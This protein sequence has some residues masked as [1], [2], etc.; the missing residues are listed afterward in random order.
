MS[1][2]PVRPPPS[3][4]ATSLSLL[5]KTKGGDPLAW[6]RFVYL[7]TPLVVRWC[8]RAGV[9]GADA[10]DIA[11]EVFVTVLDRLGGFAH[12]A[13]PGS[14]RGWLKVITRHK[15]G[16][17]IRR[18]RSRPQTAEIVLEHLSRGEDAVE[19]I[20]AERKLLAARALELLRTDFTEQTW[21]AFWRVVVD[22]RPVAEVARELG[23]SGN[24]VY[25]AKY[26]VLR[27]L[28]DEFGDL[29]DFSCG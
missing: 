19:E 1:N 21:R 8:R 2:L 25:M 3:S 7:Y 27:R 4:F 9:V 11:Q 14:F 12:G 23:V 24:A 26:R 18:S 17:Y 13:E 16:D 29:H 10:D 28:R 6:Q 20:G 5:M 22:D 15:L